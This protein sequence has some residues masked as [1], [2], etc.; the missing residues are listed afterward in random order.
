M[1]GECVVVVDG[2]IDMTATDELWRCIEQV[3]TSGRPMVLDLAR[4]TFMDSAGIHLLLRTYAAHGRV[5][6]AVTLRAPSEA[7]TR[8]LEMVGLADM[9]R[10]D[11]TPPTRPG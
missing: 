2:E 3:R 6:E 1:D 10:I 8:T 5:P 9:F 11:G 4:V 7:V